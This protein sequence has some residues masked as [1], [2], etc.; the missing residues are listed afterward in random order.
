MKGLATYRRSNDR[1]SVALDESSELKR[2]ETI[3]VQ[4]CI[5]YSTTSFRPK[6]NHSGDNLAPNAIP[7]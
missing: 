2:C 3:Q 1:S 5:C 7:N 6:G 4:K